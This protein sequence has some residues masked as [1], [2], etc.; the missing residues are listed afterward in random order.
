M[1][2][3]LMIK[4]N[5][6]WGSSRSFFFCSHWD[7]SNLFYSSHSIVD[8]WIVEGLFERCSLLFDSL[9]FCQCHCYILYIPCLL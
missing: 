4:E 2:R 1:V 8:V 3:L 6:I 7:W 5:L 9:S